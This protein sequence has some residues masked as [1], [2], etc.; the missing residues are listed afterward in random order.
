LKY[1]VNEFTRD[2][3]IKCLAK[4]DEPNEL[5]T[6]PEQK[7]TYYR[8]LQEALCNAGHHAE[9]SKVT[10]T[11]KSRGDTILFKVEDNG[12]GFNVDEVM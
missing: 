11:I 5:V 2:S 4:I 8:I 10:V 12:R 6:L 9:A 7:I 1:L 3:D